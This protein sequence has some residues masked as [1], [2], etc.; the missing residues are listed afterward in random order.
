MTPIPSSTGEKTN[1]IN[2]RTGVK[3]IQFKMDAENGEAYIG[4]EI[5]HKDPSVQEMF[6]NHFKTFKQPL[7]EEFLEEKWKWELTVAEGLTGVNRIYKKLGNVN[8]YD[9][10]DWPQIISFL[11]VRLIALDRFWNAYR[12]IFEMLQ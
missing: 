4:I 11:K 8:I 10:N 9:E 1:W 7:E 3:C 5:S 2:Y 6:F 12:D